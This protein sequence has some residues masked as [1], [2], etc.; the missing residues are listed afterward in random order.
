MIEGE[1]DIGNQ[2]PDLHQAASNGIH[3]KILFIVYGIMGNDASLCNK[4]SKRQ[5]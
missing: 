4:S 1:T 2:S 3:T 5:L